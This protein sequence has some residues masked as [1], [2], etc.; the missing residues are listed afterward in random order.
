MLTGAGGGSSGEVRCEAHLLCVGRNLGSGGEAAG[1][2][3][4]VKESWCRA[5]LVTRRLSKRVC[6]KL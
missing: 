1:E 2:S 5:G 6:E 4:S 3:G